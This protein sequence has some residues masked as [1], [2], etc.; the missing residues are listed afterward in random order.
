MARPID[1]LLHGLPHPPNARAAVLATS[2]PAHPTAYLLD[3]PAAPGPPLHRLLAPLPL[4]TPLSPP[5]PNPLHLWVGLLLPHTMQGPITFTVGG[6]HPPHTW[7]LQASTH[8]VNHLPD[9]LVG[10]LHLWWVCPGLLPDYLPLPLL[11][12]HT[13]HPLLHTLALP[14][15]TLGSPAPVCPLVAPPRVQG[16]LHNHQ[17]VFPLRLPRVTLPPVVP[18][19]P[20]EHLFL[21]HL[22]SHQPPRL[23]QPLWLLI[24][25][26][27]LVV[28]PGPQEEVFHNMMK[29]TVKMKCQYTESQHLS[30]KLRIPSATDHRVQY[31]YVT[32][33]EGIIIHVAAQTLLLSL[34]RIVN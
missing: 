12:H 22:V 8:L 23:Y 18:H 5:V 24:T 19:H 1:H 20:Q 31:F 15:N 9:L 25:Q 33:T 13:P 4:P 21:P 3:L 7:C 27:I 26:C 29:T 32:G 17:E 10:D 30:P 34:F 28:L 16:L 14:S 2:H 11:L 6:H